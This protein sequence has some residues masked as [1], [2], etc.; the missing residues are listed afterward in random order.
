MSIIDDLLIDVNNYPTDNVQL[1][2]TVSGFGAHISQG[3][4]GTFTVR[5]TNDGHLDM[6]N[7]R[8]HVQASNFTAVGRIPF[9]MT[10]SFISEARDV[11]AGSART[12]GTYFL[13]ALTATGDQGTDNEELVATHISSYDASL[14]HILNDHSHHASQPEDTLVRHI[15]PK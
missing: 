9:S 7:L 8:L 14:H 1:D 10:N 2:L 15:H 11:K 6:N 3:E 5:V 13:R 12:F 4:T